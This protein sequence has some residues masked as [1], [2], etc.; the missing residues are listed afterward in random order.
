MG[1]RWE[2]VV[3]LRDVGG[4][5]VGSGGGVGSGCYVHVGMAQVPGKGHSGSKIHVHVVTSLRAASLPAQ[6]HFA[7]P[8]HVIYF[9]DVKTATFVLKA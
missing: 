3:V 6:L 8:H 5:G 2:G 1:R 4:V 9:N 7:Q